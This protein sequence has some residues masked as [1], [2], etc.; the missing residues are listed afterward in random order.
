MYWILISGGTID[1]NFSQKMVS[2]SSFNRVGSLP[3]LLFLGKFKWF[4]ETTKM[5]LVS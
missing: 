4:E 1:D 5:A 3:V 2:W